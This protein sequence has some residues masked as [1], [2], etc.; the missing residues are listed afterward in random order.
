MTEPGRD[1]E[2]M[3]AAQPAIRPGKAVRWSWIWLVP[4]LAVLMGAS[5][6]VTHWLRTGPVITVTFQS[7]EGLAAGQTKL[8]YK[9]VIVG[10]VSAL[11]VADDRQ[12]VQVDIQL[13]QDGS[14]YIT[15]KDA[16]FWVVRPQLSL[17]GVSGLGTLMSGVYISVDAPTE[18]KGPRTYQFT[19]LE[20]PPE[21]TSGRQG[22]RY[23]LRARD[24]GSLDIG[25]GVYYRRI[26]VGRVVGYEMA[27]DGRSVLI[28]FFVDAPYDRFVT[29]DSRFWNISGI[30]VTLSPEGINMRIAGLSSV[31]SGGVA[32]AQADEVS[33]YDGAADRTPA[34]RD[35]E[36]TLFATR[37]DA[38]ADPDG[39]PLQIVMRFD[40]SVRGLRVGAP[41]D[42]RGLELGN[43]VDIDLEFD[44]K[45]RHFFARVRADLYPLR[46]AEAYDSLL[47]AANGKSGEELFQSLVDHGMRAQLRSAALVTGQQ[48]VALDFFP[49][50]KPVTETAASAGGAMGIPTVAGDLNQLQRQVGSIV[51]KLDAVPFKE[52]GEN[53]DTSLKSLNSLLEQFDTRLTPQ[54]TAALK[55]V[56][57]SFDRIGQTLGPEAPLLGGL[58]STL[59]ELERAARA[60]RT[61]A[62]YLQAHPQALVRGHPADNLH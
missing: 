56:Q 45:E 50:T 22:T 28:Q 33:S 6:L 35:H 29:A 54:A 34:A 11:R 25:T 46:F 61:L 37:D 12:G 23:V 14:E 31:L 9:D 48:Y 17:T 7:A 41:V 20:H 39:P 30:D 40:Q 60:L 52:I 42:F 21:V 44:P 15:Q 51:S 58:Q 4:L 16:H 38:L 62:D 1:D 53:L 59:G 27:D 32:F 43:V 36:F 47:A 3:A 57:R 49:K 26:L 2:S 19:G 13:D 10:Q 8:R 5:L 55:S 18:V 24:L